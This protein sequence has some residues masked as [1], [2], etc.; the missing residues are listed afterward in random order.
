MS[1]AELLFC[2]TGGGAHFGDIP[3]LSCLYHE[4]M[5]PHHKASSSPFPSPFPSCKWSAIIKKR[6]RTI[7]FFRSFYSDQYIAPAPLT[8]PLRALLLPHVLQEV[9]TQLAADCCRLTSCTANS[10]NSH[11]STLQTNMGQQRVWSCSSVVCRESSASLCPFIMGGEHI[12][13]AQQDGRKE[14]VQRMRQHKCW[15]LQ[16]IIGVSQTLKCCAAI[17]VPA[18]ANSAGQVKC[19]FRRLIEVSI[20]RLWDF[21]RVRS[22]S[23]NHTGKKHLCNANPPGLGRQPPLGLIVVG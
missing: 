2:N 17:L 4:L 12:R 3:L 11:S 21:S 1:P 22:H 10:Q 15:A 14:A 16:S 23:A 5:L 6:R 7:T 13:Q 9:Q 8:K 19:A 20:W 18:D